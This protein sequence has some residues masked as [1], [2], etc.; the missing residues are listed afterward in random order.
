MTCNNL[1]NSLF[2][3]IV[4]TITLLACYHMIQLTQSVD[5]SG[6]WNLWPECD[7]GLCA[8]G[9]VA[10]KNAFVDDEAGFITLEVDYMDD[11]K[12]EEFWKAFMLI[13][14]ETL[15][16]KTWHIF[17]SNYRRIEWFKRKLAIRELPV[18]IYY[19]DHSE[20]MDIDDDVYNASIASDDQLEVALDRDA[21][22]IKDEL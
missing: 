11:E 10:W 4:F 17:K 22:D 21:S 5:D 19:L 7:C 6:A 1:A 2:W 13:W 8:H 20:D 12:W 16:S 9:L 15:C 3:F 18:N 14:H